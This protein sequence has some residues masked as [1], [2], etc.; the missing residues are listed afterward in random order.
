MIKTFNKMGIEG[1]FLNIINAICDRP[2]A[3][4]ILNM[5]DQEQVK[6]AQSHKFYSI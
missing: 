6:D 1:T 2:T 4:I 5:M 3:N